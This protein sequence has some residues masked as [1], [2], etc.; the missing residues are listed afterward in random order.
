MSEADNGQIIIK[1]NDFGKVVDEMMKTFQQTSNTLVTGRR[2]TFNDIAFFLPSMNNEALNQ[3]IIY[4]GENDGGFFD[5]LM[6][7]GEDYVNI[8]GEGYEPVSNYTSDPFFNAQSLENA[9]TIKKGSLI[10]QKEEK[11]KMKPKGRF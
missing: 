9:P 8:S 6:I 4:W 5:E 10:L 3:Q 2:V 7:L 1:D 11:R